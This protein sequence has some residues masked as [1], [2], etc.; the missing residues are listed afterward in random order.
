MFYVF[1]KIQAVIQATNQTILN[2]RERRHKNRCNRLINQ[3]RTCLRSDIINDSSTCYKF[4]DELA[5]SR[6]QHY[7]SFFS[8]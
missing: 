4:L 1:E 2:V 5:K 6:C 7:L 3:Y 8:F